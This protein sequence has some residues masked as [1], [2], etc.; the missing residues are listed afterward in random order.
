M[1]LIQDPG[2]ANFI[3]LSLLKTSSQK[4]LNFVQYLDLSRSNIS[5]VDG[6]SYCTHLQIL[7]LAD[8]GIMEVENLECCPHLWKVDLSNNKIKGL[9]GLKRF[10]ALGTLDLSRNLLTWKEL[11]KIRHI[12]ILDLRLYG[13]PE[14]Q[15]DVHYRVHVVSGLPRAWMVDGNFVTS[16]ERNLVTQFFLDSALTG[17]PVRNKMNPN[18]FTPTTQKNLFQTCPYGKRTLHLMKQFP[19]NEQLNSDSDHRRIKYLAYNLQTD[20]TIGMKYTSRLCVVKMRYF[21]Y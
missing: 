20:L 2:M 14:L 17:H 5:L 12:Q 8:N 15:N 16:K 1:W 3:L 13:N 18:L 21:R 4:S 19:L 6:L 11:Q 9:D 10:I 7:I